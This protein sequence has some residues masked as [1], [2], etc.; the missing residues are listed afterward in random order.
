VGTSNKRIKICYQLVDSNADDADVAIGD[1]RMRI[2]STGNIG[3]GTTGA[4]AHK[5]EVKGQVKARTR[6]D[7]YLS[8]TDWTPF[9]G[10]MGNPTTDLGDIIYGGASG[11]STYL[12][13]DSA[14]S[15]ASGGQYL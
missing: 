1:E 6:T 8:A 3:I 10:K 5:L 11:S 7:G 14:G 4:P 2:T 13:G 15:A 12:P 9:D